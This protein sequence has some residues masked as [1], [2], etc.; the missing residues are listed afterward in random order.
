M[1]VGSARR[2][3]WRHIYCV[4]GSALGDPLAPVLKRLGFAIERRFATGGHFWQL[5]RF[6]K[7]ASGFWADTLIV[8]ARKSE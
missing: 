5:G 7:R 2:R 6:A 1:A 8:V 4:L 3:G